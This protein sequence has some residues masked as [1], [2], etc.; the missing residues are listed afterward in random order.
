V[1][2]SGRGAQRLGERERG[3]G[4]DP[5]DEASR[6]LQEHDP[7]PEPKSPKAATKSKVLHR[8]R[9]RQQTK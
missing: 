8:W 4:L 1:R 7:K 2:L 9:R 5:E 3:L 6:W